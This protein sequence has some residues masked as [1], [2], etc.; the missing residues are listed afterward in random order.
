MR[1]ISNSKK[2]TKSSVTHGNSRKYFAKYPFFFHKFISRQF[3]LL[4]KF[5]ILTKNPNTAHIVLKWNKTC[6]IDFFVKI[7]VSFAKLLN[8]N[9][10]EYSLS[11]SHL[12]LVLFN[13]DR[14]WTEKTIL[15]L[16]SR[17]IVNKLFRGTAN[18]S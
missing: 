16:L 1:N 18:I 10:D 15:V 13:N 8:F 17:R 9:L 14:E 3:F 4:P 5:F 7:F 6:Y 12:K 11:L 2:S